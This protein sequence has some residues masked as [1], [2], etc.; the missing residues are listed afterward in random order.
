MVGYNGAL[1][2]CGGVLSDTYMHT[3]HVRLAVDEHFKLQAQVET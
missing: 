2:M 1:L 3:D